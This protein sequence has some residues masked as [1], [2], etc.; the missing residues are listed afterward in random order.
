MAIT[1]AVSEEP[2]V[3]AARAVHEV[4]AAH[5]DDAERDARMHDDARDALGEARLFAAVAPAECGGM[6]LTLP[7]L[8]RTV[9][10][11][12]EA[13]P[14][15]AWH[16]ANSG[17]AGL[18][19][20]RL[21]ATVRAQVYADPSYPYGNGAVPVGRAL[22]VDGGFRL[23]GRWPF[24][25]GSDH[26][27]WLVLSGLIDDGTG[28]AAQYG[29]GAAR[30]FVVPSSDVQIEHT[31]SASSAMRGTGS[32][33]VR[34]EDV[35]VANQ[36]VVG[37]TAPPLIDRPMNNI[38]RPLGF[39]GM[40][41]SLQLGV[42]RTAIDGVWELA[43]EAV[44]D[45]HGGRHADQPRFQQV[46]AEAE[47]A[48]DAMRSSWFAIAD[49]LWSAAEQGEVP[50]S[51]R[52]RGFGAMFHISDSTRHQ[53]SN[54]YSIATHGAYRTRNRVERALRDIHAAAA[55]TESLRGV[56]RDVARVLAGGDPLS[57]AF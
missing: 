22:A 28:S 42:L 37:W 9:E 23:R 45:L 50:L 31:W 34:V 11:L 19:S 49:E 8:W 53:V 3:T 26:A 57:P 12:S 54:L 10:L 18:L 15:V 29:S 32:N 43:G 4:V 47:A 38:S 36:F 40:M 51:T 30:V 39:G 6:D 41:A 14:T 52:A 33:P 35:Y 25:T 46:I 7:D 21:D 17:I 56:Q 5:R 48:L 20:V 1:A 13:D 27:R 55:S 24:V 44:S 2:G 16:V